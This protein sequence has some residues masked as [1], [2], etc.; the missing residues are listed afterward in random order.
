MYPAVLV[1]AVENVTVTLPDVA[2]IVKLK[3]APMKLELFR[4]SMVLDINV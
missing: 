3:L 4:V 1:T 2:L